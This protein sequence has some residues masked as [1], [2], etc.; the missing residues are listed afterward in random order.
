MEVLEKERPDEALEAERRFL[1]ARAARYGAGR[2]VEFEVRENTHMDTCTFE[3]RE[4]SLRGRV[5]CPLACKW[6]GL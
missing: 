6:G 2:A 3:K 4:G 5:L 1:E